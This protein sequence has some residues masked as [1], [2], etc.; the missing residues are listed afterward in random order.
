MRAFNDVAPYTHLV[1]AEPG[2]PAVVLRDR[3]RR[4]RTPPSPT[5]RSTS[6]SSRS[7]WAARGT[8]PTSPTPRSRWCCRS[9]STTRSTSATTPAD[10]RASRRPGSS[11]PARSRCSPSSARGRRGA[12]APRRRG[13][14]HRR[15]RGH[16][17]R[18]RHPGPRGR[19][20]GRVAAGPAGPLRRRLPAALRRPPGAERRGRAG[21]GRGLRSGDQASRS[22]TSW[23][24][25]RSPRS[26][27]RAGSRSSG[28]AP[29]SCSTPR[30][31][32]TAPRPWPPRSR[33]PSRSRPLIGVIGVMADKDAEGLLAAL[34]PH[35]AHVVVH[36]ELHRPR[37]AGRASSPP[38]HRGLRRGPRHGRPAAGRRDRRGRRRWPRPATPSATRSAPAR[39]WSPARW[40]PS[41][42]P[43]RC[44]LRSAPMSDPPTEPRPRRAALAAPRH[45][46]GDALASRRSR[47][48]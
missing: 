23:S 5:P 14:R 26:P 37:D 45:V 9:P 46:R 11:S 6:P 40:S 10:D 43:A 20:P 27:R 47:W 3:G 22:T 15:P 38:P 34:E 35:L 2:P 36:P 8:P 39:C 44:C 13:R 32:R 17:V 7:A 48:A 41:G 4:W 24:A 42:R 25:R 29:R 16:G 18:R 31:T 19:R 12:A 1:D 33:T 30:T 28:A 21:R